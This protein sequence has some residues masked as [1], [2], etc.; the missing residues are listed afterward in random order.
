MVDHTLLLPHTIFWTPW[1]LEVHME[2]RCT[3]RQNI[4]N[5]IDNNNI[6]NKQQQ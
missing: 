4:Y 6:N 5:K 2:H 3:L 1:A